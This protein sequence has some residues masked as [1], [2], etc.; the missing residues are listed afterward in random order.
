MELLV[1]NLS[2]QHY[3]K[4]LAQIDN[5]YLVLVSYQ[6]NTTDI[7]HLST[8]G[9]KLFLRLPRAHT[10]AHQ[11]CNRLILGNEVHQIFPASFQYSQTF[12]GDEITSY[13]T[14]DSQVLLAG[15]VQLQKIGVYMI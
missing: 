14:Y 3:D 15:S 10:V 12:Y 11:H 8:E 5:D 9:F 6:F 1:E 7:V 2:L 13:C 4:L